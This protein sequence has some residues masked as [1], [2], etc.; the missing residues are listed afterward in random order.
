MHMRM[1]FVGTDGIFMFYDLQSMSTDIK[2]AQMDLILQTT[3]K[4]AVIKVCDTAAAEMCKMLQ[5]Q[6]EQNNRRSEVI[7]LKLHPIFSGV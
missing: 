6:E 1:T 2:L 4:C 7:K 5:R 3:W